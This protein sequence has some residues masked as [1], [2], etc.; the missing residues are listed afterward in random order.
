[1]YGYYRYGFNGKENDNEVK[2]SGNQQD[3]GMRIYDTR[4]GRFLSVDPLT[5]NYPELTPYQFASN[6][7]IQAI[8]I[9]GAEAGKYENPGGG[10]TYL[11]IG[12]ENADYYKENITY[13]ITHNDGTKT[14]LSVKAGQLRSFTLDGKNYSASW[15]SNATFV[16][17]QSS[18]ENKTVYS[19]EDFFT[20]KMQKIYNEGKFA[21]SADIKF[22]VGFQAEYK[23]SI[24]L[25]KSNSL[26]YKLGGGTY[27][28]ESDSYGAGYQEG[29][30]W[31][32][33]K[34][35]EQRIHNYFNGELGGKILGH[36]LG[37]G[38]KGDYSTEYYNSY[39]RGPQSI[40]GSGR[41]DYSWYFF[42]KSRA[43][44]NFVPHFVEPSFK[45]KLGVENKSGKSFFGLDF[46]AGAKL[47]L[48]VDVKF[49][50]GATY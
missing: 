48:G 28:F 18:D 45:P 21:S 44:Q 33:V 50:V 49:R 16:G 46:G 19:E 34:G 27:T 20:A 42:G 39:G 26:S 2:G 36:S 1:M 43:P 13:N 8:D 38:Y 23:G 32:G 6:T 5:K 35:S 22:S 7:P 15:N 17:Y 25:N 4:L 30:F 37:V 11:P 14:P 12:A 41:Y 3:Y 9:D 47:I 29:E 40:A 24:G 10:N 31:K